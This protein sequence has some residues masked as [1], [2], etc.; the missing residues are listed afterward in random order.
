MENHVIYKITNI[1]NGKVYIG[2]T[3]NFNRRM[4]EHFATSS[5]SDSSKYNH[6]LY[7]SIRKYGWE[8]FDK[9]ILEEKLTRIEANER[10]KFWIE[11]YQSSD[12]DFGYN[13]T[14]GGE[15]AQTASRLSKE[16][17]QSIVSTIQRTSKTFKDIGFQFNISESTISAINLGRRW[18]NDSLQYPLRASRISEEIWESIAHDLE[19]RTLKIKDIAKKYN[20]TESSVQRFNQGK[21]H[22]GFWHSYPIRK[23]RVL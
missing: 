1:I 22:K 4:N 3:N 2:L 18:R 5:N 11:S 23:K 20:I 6:H 16:E 12:R 15:N 7:A 17:I 8:N 19:Q 14:E 9:T 13:L 10:E 21:S